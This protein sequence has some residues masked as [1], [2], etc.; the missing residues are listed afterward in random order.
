[1]F[2]VTVYRHDSITPV[3]YENVKH[4]WW[5]GDV[6]CISYLTGGVEHRG[7]RSEVPSHDYLWWPR[8]RISHVRVEHVK[9]GAL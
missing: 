8:E 1:M 3:V 2:R 9:D 7:N 5:Q 6:L 4:A